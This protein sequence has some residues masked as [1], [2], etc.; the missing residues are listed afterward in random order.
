MRGRVI[1]NAQVLAFIEAKFVLAVERRAAPGLAQDA[2]NAGIIGDEKR[3]RRRAHEHFYARRARQPFELGNIAGVVMGAAD[4]KGEIAMHAACRARHFVGERRVARGQ[5]VRIGH[6]ENGGDAAHDRRAG[7][8]LQI[9]LMRRAGLAEM[10]LRVDHARQNMEA[11]GV[12]RLASAGARKI[13]DFGDFSS[14]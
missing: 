14:R 5:G 11:S 9:F 7:A 10:H 4:P 6:F 3:A 12:D 8:G 13:A 1:G 2:G